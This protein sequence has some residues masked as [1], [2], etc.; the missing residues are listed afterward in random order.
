MFHSR[1]V[2]SKSL[3]FNPVS[4]FLLRNCHNNAIPYSWQKPGIGCIKLNFDG[5][6]KCGSHSASIGGVYRNHEGMFML[7]YAERIGR[8]TSS[9]AE[10]VAA[11][12]GL[13][14]A[15]ENGWFNIWLEGDAKNVVDFVVNGLRLKS[16]EDE[17][18]GREIQAL[19]KQLDVLNASHIYR[20]GNR[21]ADKFAKMG[22]HYKLNKPKVWRDVA[23]DEVLRFLKQDAEG[24][25]FMHKR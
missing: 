11:R 1:L 24:Q 18:H 8:A 3:G 9:V 22:Y 15:L 4:L 16:K 21:V 10:F 14:L 25:I 23:P 5:A 12:R 20:R 2:I 7:G 13:E 19:I 17:G 6:S